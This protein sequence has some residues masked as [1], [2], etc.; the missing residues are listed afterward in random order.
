[1]TKNTNN[2]TA[3]APYSARSEKSDTSLADDLKQGKGKPAVQQS[4]KVLVELGPIV[5]FMLTYNIMQRMLGEEPENW[6]GFS[7]VKSDAIFVATA[8]FM[9]AT[10]IALLY[11]VFK[12]KRTPPMLIVSAVI[13]GV[14]G[15]LTLY[16]QSPIFIYLKPTIINLL[17]AAVIFGGLAIGKNVWQMLFSSAFDLPDDAWR[18][19]AMRWGFWFVFLAILNEVIWRNFSES[20][21]ANFKVFGVMPLTIAFMLAQMPLLMKYIDVEDKKKT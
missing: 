8:V 18:I 12:V 6:F 5:I 17:Y 11:S 13:V 20:F 16:L 2:E 7:L 1:M 4:S 21:W 3:N 19:F 9:V 15:G 14:F 10:A